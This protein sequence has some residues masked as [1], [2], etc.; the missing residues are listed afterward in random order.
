MG[1]CQD[2]HSGEHISSIV[3]SAC[4]GHQ[5]KT[6]ISM[7]ICAALVE[8]GLVV[9]PFKK[10]MDYIDPS[11]LTA[12]AGRPCRNLDAFLMPREDILASFQRASRGADLALMEGVMGLY[13][14]YDTGSEGSTAWMARPIGA[15]VVLIVNASRMTRSV[16]AMVTGYQN[17]EPDTRVAAVILNNVSL[18]GHRRKLLAAIEQYCHVPVLGCI[19]TDSS[20]AI[21]EQHLGL[22]PYRATPDITPDGTGNI[23]RVRDV[24]KKYI[25]LDGLLALAKTSNSWREPVSTP[26][27]GAS[28][29]RIGVALDRAFNFYYPEN[30][31][32]LRQAGA[33]LVFINTLTDTFLPDV[34]GFYIGGGFPELFAEGL[35]ANRSLRQDIAQAVEDGTPVYAEC[36]GV[37]YLCQGIVWN[38]QRHEMVGVLPSDVE[39]HKETQGHGYVIAEVARENPWLPVGTTFRGHQFHHSRLCHPERVQFAYA[40]KRRRPH[41]PEVDGIIHGNVIA[42]YTHLHVFS[43]PQ[44]ARA[45]VSLALREKES[46]RR[47]VST[48]S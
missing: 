47:E 5:G 25:D 35:E 29:V 41:D 11:W 42:A 1:A 13:D 4:Q 21:R 36:G 32:A 34:D 24:I 3:I 12:A 26:P 39:L 23:A 20:L 48:F 45:F 18:S 14:S 33:E 31:E 30:L 2:T 22:R 16:A 10:G 28:V 46:R 19:P 43:L 44:W 38:G 6:T 17:F 27:E 37:M 7:G 15:P 8:K 9:Q 40:M